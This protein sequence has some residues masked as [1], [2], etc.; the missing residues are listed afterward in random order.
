MSGV[1]GG[2]ELSL[3]GVTLVPPGSG[4]SV[5]MGSCAE[6]EAE[7][8]TGRGGGGQVRSEVFVPGGRDRTPKRERT[9]V[10]PA[11]AR[12][13]GRSSAKGGKLG[14]ARAAGHPPVIS[15]SP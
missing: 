5:R 3:L 6:R 7:A 1:G 11:Q 4:A 13:A 9:E 2:L 12:D 10:P 15:V 8:E 14:T